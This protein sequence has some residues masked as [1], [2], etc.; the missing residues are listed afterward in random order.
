MALVT[1]LA[2]SLALLGIVFAYFPGWFE[3]L[4]SDIDGMPIP[5]PWGL[6]LFF[7][8]FGMIAFYWFIFPA[9][10]VIANRRGH[11]AKNKV[12]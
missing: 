1:G 8:V 12:N 11:I 9:V 5:A 3:Q 6:T 7:A 2:R 4:L 10:C